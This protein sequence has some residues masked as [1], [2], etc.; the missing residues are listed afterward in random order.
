MLGENIKI[1][2]TKKGLSQEELAIRLN[3]VRQTVS[4]WEKGISV[5]DAEMLALIANELDS[6]VNVLLEDTANDTDSELKE[7]NDKLESITKQ[8]ESYNELRRKVKRRVFFVLAAFG[9]CAIIYMLAA[10]IWSMCAINNTPSVGIIGG[11]DAPTT[12]LLSRQVFQASPFIIMLVLE[13]IA[14][15][16]IYK[17]RKK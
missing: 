10:F 15:T 13:I 14:L 7:I 12:I 17:T 5:P 3:V 9:A 4:K 6:S 11:A 16:G 1:F 8:L 2:R